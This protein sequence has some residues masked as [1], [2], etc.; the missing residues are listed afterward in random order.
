MS[1]KKEKVNVKVVMLG[2]ELG[3]KTSLVGRFL[4]GNF[5]AGKYRSTVAA[6]YNARRVEID[7]RYVIIGIWDTAGTERFDCITRIYYRDAFAAIVCYDLT[8][9][10]SFEKA[11]FW[12]EELVYNHPKCRVY[13]C[14]TKKDLLSEKFPTFKREVTL[15]KVSSF[16]E[17]LNLKYEPRFY[18]TSSKSGQCV[19]EIFLQIAREYL[20]DDDTSDEGD[21]AEHSNA[22][23]KI[24]KLENST[25]KTNKKCQSC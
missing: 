10:A 19:D 9:R 8:D 18:E 11:V 1:S 7:G 16:A 17:S 5:P 6:D 2:K 24:V 23:G 21:V 20:E 3:G 12:V 13:F 15:E 4:F 14:G 25:K 22:V